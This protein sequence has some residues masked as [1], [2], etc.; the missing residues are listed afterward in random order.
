MISTPGVRKLAAAHNG[1][2]LGVP[3]GSLIQGDG[4]GRSVLPAHELRAV[5]A[6]YSDQHGSGAIARPVAR[7]AHVIPYLQRRLIPAV[8]QQSRD[9]VGFDLPDLRCLTFPSSVDVV[10]DVGVVEPDLSDDAITGLQRIDV[11]QRC[12]GMMRKRG[13][14]QKNGG[15]CDREPG[16]DVDVEPSEMVAGR[17]GL[18]WHPGGW[19]SLA[20]K[21]SAI[22]LF[23]ESASDLQQEWEH[24]R[25]LGLC[26][27]P[28]F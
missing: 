25:W 3:L 7:K 15:Q 6:D 22:R 4:V 27:L 1:R 20:G 21:R 26:C 12:G 18:L 9:I 8:H 2:V 14:R 13:N 5:F 10:A 17:Q 19:S 28:T 23:S 11:E 16:K 24:L